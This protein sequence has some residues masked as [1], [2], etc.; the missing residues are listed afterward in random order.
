M[1][2]FVKFSPRSSLRTI[3]ENGK[4]GSFRTKKTAPQKTGD[5]IKH[6]KNYGENQ[7]FRGKDTKKINYKSP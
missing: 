2:F 4:F 5:G 7:Q 6:N 3:G 1:R